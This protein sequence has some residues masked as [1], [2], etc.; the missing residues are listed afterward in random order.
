MMLVMTIPVRPC[1]GPLARAHRSADGAPP[2][3]LAQA[4]GPQPRRRSSGQGAGTVL[5]VRLPGRLNGG[6]VAFRLALPLRCDRLPNAAALLT[7]DRRGEPPGFPRLRGAIA[8]GAPPPSCVRVAPSGPPREPSPDAV[9]TGGARRAPQPRAVLGGPPPS[10]GVQGLEALGRGVARG[11]LTA[12]VAPRR[13][14]PAAGLAGPP[15]PRGRWPPRP[16][17]RAP[18][19]PS[20]GDARGAGGHDGLRR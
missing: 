15:L 8:R 11:V 20:A 4:R 5:T 14:G 7:A 13:A 6:G 1:E 16:L 18:G 10:H 2:G 17:I 3:L 19:W 12:G 9:G